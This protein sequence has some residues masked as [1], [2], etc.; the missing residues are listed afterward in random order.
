MPR[1]RTDP[2]RIALEDKAA[3]LQAECER[4]YRRMRAAFNRLEKARRGLARVV[5]RIDALDAQPPLAA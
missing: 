4:H 1:K 2:R 3:K 5:K